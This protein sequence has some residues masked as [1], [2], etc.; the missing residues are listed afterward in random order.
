MDLTRVKEKAAEIL[1]PGKYFNRI[2][3][4]LKKLPNT[5][6]KPLLFTFGGVFVLFLIILII[7]LAAHS[8][9]PKKSSPVDMAV[10]PVIPMEDLFIPAEP[11]FLPKFLPE[12]EP[13]TS[14]SVEDIRPYWKNPGNPELWQA[15][16][17]S[18]VDKLMEA[19][20]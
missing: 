15:E 3:G 13:K 20:P 7:A 10:V 8:P 16:I 4:T 9:K 5:K 17:K 11:D 19:V 1:F 14:W 18:A 6:K 12:R 2:K